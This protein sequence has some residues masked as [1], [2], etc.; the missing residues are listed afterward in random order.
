VK[1]VMLRKN[2]KLEGEN[3]MINNF[4][5]QISEFLNKL[6]ETKE[7]TLFSIDGTYVRDGEIFGV[8]MLRG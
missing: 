6:L 4:L 7:K 2:Y 5:K 1:L 8:S 3:K